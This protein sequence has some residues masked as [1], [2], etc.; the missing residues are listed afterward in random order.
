LH[1]SCREIRVV[2]PEAHSGQD[3][4]AHNPKSYDCKLSNRGKGL[5][6]S[7]EKECVP[8]VALTHAEQLAREYANEDLITERPSGFSMNLAGKSQEFLWPERLRVAEFPR[9]VD[10]RIPHRFAMTG[11][12]YRNPSRNNGR[13]VGGLFV[14]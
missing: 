7:W 4:P 1:D 11:R 2:V 6:H 5:R 13:P 10:N 9:D 12:P 14:S 3:V 8:T